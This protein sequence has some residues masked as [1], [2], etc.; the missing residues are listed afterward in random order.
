M[1]LIFTKKYNTD[2]NIQEIKVDKYPII[3][4]SDSHCN[5]SNIKKLKELYP[6]NQFICLGDICF[7]FSKPGDKFNSYSIDYFANN[8]IPCLLGNHDS[9]VLDCSI[10]N[11]LTKLDNIEDKYDLNQQQINYLKKLPIGF[12]LIRPDGKYYLLYHNKPEELWS[13]DN[14]NQTEEE[15]LK[16]YKLVNK[17]CLGVIRGH[18][19][20]N[21]IVD[22][23]EIQTKLISIGRLSVNGDY[24]LLMENGIEYKKI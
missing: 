23:P 14:K 2:V 8:N 18:Y 11:S 19:H 15:F 22:Y 13:M 1:S 16:T 10:G 5:L 3:V 21:F 4:F 7:L 20:R 12:K 9:H 6:N 17:D 24:V